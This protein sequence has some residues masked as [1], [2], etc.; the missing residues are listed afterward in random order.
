MQFLIKIK[1]I[2][3]KRSMKIRITESQFNLIKSLKEESSGDSTIYVA[4]F[5]I[6][7]KAENEEI[8][9]KSLEVMTRQVSDATRNAEVYPSLYQKAPFGG[10]S[11]KIV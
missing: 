2:Y 6:I 9:K 3:N 1:H 4:N 11:E 7:F 10:K 8:A 5:E